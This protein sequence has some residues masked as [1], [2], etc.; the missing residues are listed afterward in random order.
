[1]FRC[2]FR[3]VTNILEDATTTGPLSSLPKDAIHLQVLLFTDGQDTSLPE[4]AVSAASARSHFDA[5]KSS[6]SQMGFDSSFFYVAAYSQD[7]DPEQCQYMSDKYQYIDLPDTLQLKLARL[8]GEMT[9]GSGSAVM[10][11]K[12]P[13]GYSLAEPIPQKLPLDGNSLSYHV[14]VKSS[15]TPRGPTHG[16]P[17]K[18]R[19]DVS[20]VGSELQEAEGILTPVVLSPGSFE[21]HSFVLDRAAFQLRCKSREM[22]GKAKKEDI[23]SLRALL[24][25]DRRDIY[26]TRKAA[27]SLPYI[28]IQEARDCLTKENRPE[29][30]I[31]RE[32]KR[33]ELRAKI[34]IIETLADRLVH[35]VGEFERGQMTDARVA[36]ILGDSRQHLPA[37]TK[38]KLDMLSIANAQRIRERESSL[39]KIP[40]MPRLSQY[41]AAFTK[42]AFS[43]C[44][45]SELGASGDALFFYLQDFHGNT[46]KTPLSAVH[47]SSSGFIS[48][49][50]FT[51]LKTSGMKQKNS[52][53]STFPGIGE[54][55]KFWLPCYFTKEHFMVGMLLQPDA[56]G[57]LLHSDPLAFSES[58]YSVLLD[59]LGTSV[60][61]TAQTGREVD[62]VLLCHKA[63]SYLAL[64]EY[65]PEEYQHLNAA[66]SPSSSSSLSSSSSVVSSISLNRLV[67]EAFSSS[68]QGKFDDMSFLRSSVDIE[69]QNLFVN[70]LVSS[71]QSLPLHGVLLQLWLPLFGLG[72]LSDVSSLFTLKN[73]PAVVPDV[74]ILYVKE[75]AARINRGGH[76]SA[77]SIDSRDGG[78]LSARDNGGG[79]SVHAILSICGLLKAFNSSLQEQAFKK[80]IDALFLDD[81]SHILDEWNNL[82]QK[83]RTQTIQYQQGLDETKLWIMIAKAL[84]S[85][86]LSLYEK[87]EAKTSS[88]HCPKHSSVD[89]S[90]DK[91]E[92]SSLYLRILRVLHDMNKLFPVFPLTVA[93]GKAKRNQKKRGTCSTRCLLLLARYGSLCVW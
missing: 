25:L 86:S 36:A 39:L 53:D 24:D 47:G 92:D 48:S 18:F 84:C 5:M 34:A 35:V 67:G 76:H 27:V 71:L 74:N 28:S 45:A 66:H 2:A 82:L 63:R 93:E 85:A 90:D 43:C 41:G 59:I 40:P 13:P 30:G 1:M 57:Y 11:V 54:V 61:H 78:G 32:F 12:L 77:L 49:E 37:Q 70:Y 46:G 65:L 62:F 7:H 42:D 4:K 87:E 33:K 20:A 8:M 17:S 91:T 56:L 89:G 72:Q 29:S 83:L 55:V 19:I 31:T 68:L 64:K 79:L 9:S 73:K 6:I 80:L 60:I 3:Q 15:E 10:N 26:E 69:Y 16:L 52:L 81:D 58:D 75:I 51:S 14:F 50:A 88:G 23:Q 22:D 38:R 44:N 21:H